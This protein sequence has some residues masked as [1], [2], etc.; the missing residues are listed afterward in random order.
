MAERLIDNSM[1][2][3]V[4]QA[5]EIFPMPAAVPAMEQPG[6][7][8]GPYELVQILGTGGMGAVWEAAQV[9]PVRRKVALKLIKAGMDTAQVVARFAAERQALA[10]MDHPNIAKV[11]DA[12][13]VQPGAIHA[14][15][16][17][18][19]M[20]LVRGIPMTT[21]CDQERLTPRER[22]EL[23]IPVCQAV[24]H[25]HQ[26]GIIHRDLKPSNVL[27]G[28]YD[29]KPVPKVIDF[30]V[31]KATTASPDD[32]TP[33]TH[34]G[35]V[36]GTPIYMAPEQADT[37][38]F[39]IDTRADIYALGVILYELLTGTTPF[40]KQQIKNATIVEMFRLIKE[41][42]PVKP[43][44]KLSS[45]ENLAEL[46]EQR[47]L[48][49]KRLTSQ[50]AG[51]LDWIVMKCLEKDRDRRYE[52]ANGL[53]LDIQRFLHDEPVLAGP[54]SPAYR[55]KKFV[56]RNRV[57]VMAG[58]MV[59]ATLL[60]GMAGTTWGLIHANRARKVAE[61]QTALAQAVQGFLQ[62]DLL[63]QADAFVQAETL[64]ESGLSADAV[65]ENPTI[66]ELLDRAA[67]KLT[68][69][70][71]EGRF[72]QQPTVQSEILLTVGNSYRAIGEFDKAI[73]L[74][75]RS[76]D[77]AVRTNGDD[78]PHTLEAMDDLAQA[79]W[80]ANRPAEAIP[81]LEKVCSGRQ[82]I[83]G[84]THEHTFSSRN[85]LALAVRDAGRINDAIAQLQ[86]L[87]QQEAK[88]IGTTHPESLTTLNSLGLCLRDAGKPQEAIPLFE[89]VRDEWKKLK[90][91]GHPGTLIAAS[92]LAATLELAGQSAKAI[93]ILEEVRNEQIK[94]IG[95]DHPETLTTMNNLAVAMLSAGRNTEA[96]D[97]L[98][99]VRDRRIEKLGKDHEH[100]IATML[101][102]AQAYET[103]KR[104][105]DAIQVFQQVCELLTTKIGPEQPETL[106]AMVSLA[107]AYRDFD[108]LP[109]AIETFDAALKGYI[110]K[111]G[112]DH[113][114]TLFTMIRFA[115]A[116]Q[117]AK[118][119]TRQEKLLRDAVAGMDRR[120][121]DAWQ[122]GMAKSLLGEAYADQKN[123][124]DAEKWLVAGY[125]ALKSNPG[126]VPPPILFEAL[127]RLIRLGESADRP[128]L[129]AK[130]TQERD[131]LMGKK[132]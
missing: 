96:A 115:K 12:G 98:E 33:V 53:A 124:L 65:R 56:R 131:R 31:A 15:R 63:K 100:T 1:P 82:R 83:L 108:R 107:L 84:P 46:A 58:A 34:V 97:V 104:G 26:K 28:I 48:D 71:I 4:G 10:L 74:L 24:Q 57:T 61:A 21:Y 92:N 40:T 52:T 132:P 87:R 113:P 89:Q 27:I 43:S 17:Y 23:F 35:G 75:A 3:Q 59:L 42:E 45:S 11:L 106:K 116:C 2:T 16:P 114:E 19:V 93:P 72:P 102:L 122:T 79:Y 95:A 60:V 81:I 76:V 22:L 105:T 77:L 112:P 14:G 13:M 118:D 109:D 37:Q 123:H 129:T 88:S 73:G 94:K 85:N 80:S 62:T 78:D 66:K 111:A 49:P 128:E 47:H 20:E 119:H 90:G 29:G 121:P 68:P 6:D 44:T 7:C 8:I 101:T 120:M 91:A 69:D 55:L 130:W 38:N 103:L 51:D 54:P 36:V 18:F 125:E 86:E 67:A 39:D 50:V 32:E 70:K 99:V 127:N 9:E 25:A 117:M 64:R 110:S 5:P 126:K 30:G 41:V